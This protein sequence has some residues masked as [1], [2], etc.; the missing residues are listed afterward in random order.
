M[1]SGSRYAVYSEGITQF[2]ICKKKADR[3]ADTQR[4]SLRFVAS[5]SNGFWIRV[6]SWVTNES[7]GL[8]QT[9]IL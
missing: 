8:L 9:S 5:C 7:K 2:L 6:S 4:L 1:Y 3:L